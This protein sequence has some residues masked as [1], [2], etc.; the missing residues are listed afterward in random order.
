MDEGWNRWILEQFELPYRTLHDADVR[1]GGLRARYDTILLPSID[2][3]SIREGHAAGSMPPEYCG[4]LGAEGEAALAAFVREGGRLV[5]LDA[6]CEL[7]TR[8]FPPRELPVECVTAGCDPRKFSCPGSLL[9][10]ELAPRSPLNAPL[11]VGLPQELMVPFQRSRAFAI[12]S[13]SKAIDAVARYAERDLCRSG[14]I[15]GPETIAG[16]IM[17]LV[18]S[19]GEGQVV[20]FGAP[21]QF[22]AQSEASFPLLFNALYR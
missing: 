8:M 5:C 17:A 3:R 16:K 6:S 12:T 21:V 10:V 11:L 19:V 14:W 2:A 13:D 22:R 20:L 18:A 4:G 15:L 1:A 7:A 9:A